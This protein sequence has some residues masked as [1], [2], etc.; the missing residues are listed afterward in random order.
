MIFNGK[1]QVKLQ[2]E[3][4]LAYYYTVHLEVQVVSRQLAILSHCL[5]RHMLPLQSH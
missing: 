2:L 3:V 5:H 4:E 1:L